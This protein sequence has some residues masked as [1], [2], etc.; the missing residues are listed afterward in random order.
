MTTI[1]IDPPRDRHRETLEVM[2]PDSIESHEYDGSPWT[3]REIVRMHR[4]VWRYDEWDKLTRVSAVI[5]QGY[6]KAGN[7]YQA[8]SGWIDK[9][10]VELARKHLEL[11]ARHKATTLG[12]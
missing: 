6:D 2:I 5:W 7:L 4:E 12:E 1:D 9:L 3:K 10:P 11:L 8:Y